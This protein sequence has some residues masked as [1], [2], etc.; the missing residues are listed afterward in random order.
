MKGQPFGGIIKNDIT[1]QIT[2]V[3]KTIYIAVRER[4]FEVG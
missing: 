3:V 2:I 1:C 4:F